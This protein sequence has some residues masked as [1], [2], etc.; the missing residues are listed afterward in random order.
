MIGVGVAAVRPSLVA[1]VHAR[2]VDTYCGVARN[3]FPAVGVRLC[4][5]FKKGPHMDA[6]IVIWDDILL[7]YPQFE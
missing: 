4:R 6:L 5:L 3:A 2:E 7:S 1:A